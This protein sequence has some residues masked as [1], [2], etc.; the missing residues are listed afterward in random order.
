MQPPPFNQSFEQPKKPKKNPVLVLF[1][2]LGVIF[3]CCGGPL[4]FLGYFGYKGFQGAMSMGG[5]AINAE[6]L[7]EATKAYAAANNGKLPKADEWQTALGKYLPA[8]SKRGDEAPFK[9]WKADGEWSCEEDGKKSGFVFNTDLSEKKISD[10]KPG[11]ASIAIFESRQF[12]FNKSMKYA[13]QPFEES[14][15]VMGGM[16][17]IKER[18][19][20]YVITA[21]GEVES[22]DKDGK[23]DK[24]ANSFSSGFKRGTKAGKEGFETGVKLSTEENKPE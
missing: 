21:K 13:V 15:K 22:I 17:G 16:G 8:E 1:A 5:C 4:A 12:G 9:F 10:L 19:G 18:R 23:I 6:R 7:A 3:I 14:P 24:N 20:W 2:V 11:E